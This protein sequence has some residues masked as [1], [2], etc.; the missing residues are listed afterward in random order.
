MSARLYAFRSERHTMPSSQLPGQIRLVLKLTAISAAIGA[1]Y[2]EMRIAQTGG[3]P[4]AHFGMARGAMTG[5]VIGGDPPRSKSW[6]SPGRS[7]RRCAARRLRCMWRSGQP[8]ISSSFCSASSSGRGRSCVR[9][10]AEL[11]ASTCCSRSRHSFVFVFMFEM[12]SLL[13]QNVLLNFVT[14]R[15]HRPRLEERV[16]VHRH[17]GLDGIGRAAR[18]P[19]LSPPTQPLRRS[20]SPSRSWRRA[21]KSTVT[22]ATN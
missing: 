21:A 14:G 4:F 18:P 22:S 17:G 7:D 13:G 1:A 5:V 12:N 19:R 9:G 8:S 15:Y 10:S 20:I 6:V 2:A 3:P 16:S 11:K